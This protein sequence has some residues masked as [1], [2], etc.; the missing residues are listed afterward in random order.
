MGFLA[1]LSGY[2]TYISALGLLGL[3]IFQL[4][5]GSFQA[6]LQSILAGAA[7]ASLKSAIATGP[8][9]PVVTPVPAGGGS[10]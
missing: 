7:A 4:S 10:K 9:P 1:A 3:G 6:G 5:T 2:K 8:T